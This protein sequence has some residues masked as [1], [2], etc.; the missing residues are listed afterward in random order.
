M[1]SEPVTLSDAS[2]IRQGELVTV[3]GRSFASIV[4]KE[5]TVAFLLTISDTCGKPCDEAIELMRDLAFAFR[6]NS[7]AIMAVI[8]GP[9]NDVPPPFRRNDV[10]NFCIVPYAVKCVCEWYDGDRDFSSMWRYSAPFLIDFDPETMLEPDSEEIRNARQS[11]VNI[12]D[13]NDDDRLARAKDW[14][15]QNVRAGNVFR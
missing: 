9:K 13:D 2:K 12:A 11:K 15:Q 3:V 5:G 4:Q 10:P 6:R 1:V 8:N 7:G 14:Q